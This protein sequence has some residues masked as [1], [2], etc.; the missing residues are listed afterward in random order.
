[1]AGLYHKWKFS[2]LIAFRSGLPADDALIT[3]GQRS[4]LND[5]IVYLYSRP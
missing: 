5:R 3:R 4:T 2:N 1:M